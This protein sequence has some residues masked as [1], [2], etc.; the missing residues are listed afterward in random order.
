M[1]LSSVAVAVLGLD[2]WCPPDKK[3]KERPLH[4]RLHHASPFDF[5][6]RA[7]RRH[8][9]GV[10]RPPHFPFGGA[11]RRLDYEVC[12]LA[13]FLIALVLVCVA[14]LGCQ[15]V[16]VRSNADPRTD[17]SLIETFN[18]AAPSSSASTNTT[19]PQLTEQNRQRVRAEVIKEMARRDCRLAEQ[20]RLLISI[21][22][23]STAETYDRAN[24]T[25]SGD[26]VGANLSRHYGLKY[27]KTQGD[28]PVVSYNEATL[29]FRAFDT[30]QDRLVWTG[31]AVGAL[32]Q[33]R[34]DDAVQKRIQEVVR[35]VFDKFPKT[36]K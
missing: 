1:I 8:H 15:T 36:P 17:F 35:S 23:G 31:Q 28:Q 5:D 32:F 14:Q 19:H 6:T 22:L 7:Y 11:A 34:P 18:F 13:R 4:A 24:P 2:R 12:R 27:D 9:S 21:D 25:V 20:P 33:N 26:S 29:S 10:P 16:A 3:P 30:K